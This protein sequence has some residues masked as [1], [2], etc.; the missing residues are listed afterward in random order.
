[1]KYEDVLPSPPL[2]D[3]LAF[4]PPAFQVPKLK[5]PV[6]VV[7]QVSGELAAVQTALGGLACCSFQIPFEVVIIQRIMPDADVARYVSQ[8]A[9]PHGWTQIR[10]AEVVTAMNRA[11]ARHPDRDVALL[12][13][14]IETSETG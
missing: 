7:V 1:V 3:F 6:D 10:E 9:Q 14:D 8:M 5:T 4:A 2:G 13:G 11:L 12:S